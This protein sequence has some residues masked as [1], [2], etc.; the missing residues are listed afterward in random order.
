LILRNYLI[1]QYR[2]LTILSSIAAVAPVAVE[3]ALPFPGIFVKNVFN[4]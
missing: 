3:V 1:D 4:F 2:I